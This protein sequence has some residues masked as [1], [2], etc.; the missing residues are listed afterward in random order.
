[1]QFGFSL[2]EGR[3]IDGMRDRIVR[4][5]HA[6]FAIIATQQ[7]SI[8]YAVRD[9][10]KLLQIDDYGKAARSKPPGHLLLYMFTQRVANWMNPK[11]DFQER[12]DWFQT[13]ASYL[14][15][16]LSYLV[17]I[18][19][20]YFTHKFIGQKKA[21]T[22]CILYLFIPSVNLI[23]LHTDQVFFPA[24]SMSCIFLAALACHKQH[25]A[26][27]FVAGFVIYT[28]LF[29][30]F[31]LVFVLPLVVATCFAISCT[32]E[33]NTQKFKVLMKTSL[34]I[35]AGMIVLD[36]MFRIVFNYDI[37]IRYQDAMANHIVT[38]GWDWSATTVAYFAFL[39]SL[40][41]T[42]WIGIPIAFLVFL[43][44]IRSIEHVIQGDYRIRFF[45]S[46]VLLGVFLMLTLFG[47]T[48][49]EV[50]RL[51]LFLVP[52]ICILVAD[53]VHTRF[54]KRSDWI[55]TLIVVLQ[56]GTIYLTKR[57]QDFW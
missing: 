49:A 37:W 52:F 18:P 27:S 30:S 7:E 43:H 22:A 48:K 16:L 54:G 21:T 38:K 14:W 19:M 29:C 53:E 23:T 47:Q 56:W 2:L 24:L 4:T 35:L 39:N 57:Y 51:W 15:P 41:Y 3:G 6:K 12:L 46:S 55:V 31:G 17:L 32:S 13:F 9:Y 20:F 44:W 26:L 36:I 42:V 28:T 5:G 34:G 50:A 1:M 11:T 45:L 8:F 10:E 33:K 40:E 25:L